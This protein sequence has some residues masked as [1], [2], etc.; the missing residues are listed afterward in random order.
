[1]NNII[2]IDLWKIKD[3]CTY[4]NISRTTYYRYRK[5]N[6][7][8]SGIL[9]SSHTIVWQPQEIIDWVNSQPKQS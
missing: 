9:L 2:P 5:K 1:M 4:L 8:P 6:G 3:A 7:F